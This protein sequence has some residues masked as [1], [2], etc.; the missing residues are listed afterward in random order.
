MA[1]LKGRLHPYDL[2]RF[3]KRL[4]QI[5][6]LRDEFGDVLDVEGAIW[7]NKVVLEV[8][9]DEGSSGGYLRGIRE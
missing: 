7:F 5:C 8:E 9:D 3:T 2:S 4:D 6:Y 1:R